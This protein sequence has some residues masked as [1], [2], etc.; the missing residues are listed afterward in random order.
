MPWAKENSQAKE[1]SPADTP[2]VMPLDTL[3][4]GKRFHRQR[5][6][7][8]LPG[9]ASALRFQ[10]HRFAERSPDFLR[11]PV[12]PSEVVQKVFPERVLAVLRQR[13]ALGVELP[14]DVGQLDAPVRLGVADEALRILARGNGGQIPEELPADERD[15]S[16]ARAEVLLGA[17]GD[18]PLADPG[19]DVLVDHVARDPAP[20][21]RVPDR[22]APRGNAF[23][24]VGLGFLRHA[25]KGP[26]DREHVLVVHRYAP[27]E[28]LA[29]KKTVRPQT[30]AACRPQRIAFV[31]AFAHAFV[32]VAGLELFEADLQLRG[33]VGTGA[34]LPAQAPVPV[35]P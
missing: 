4:G 12:V 5:D 24:L 2:S 7:R 17:V 18:A 30:H 27:L 31:G 23:L 33:R 19:D 8:S 25:D 34:A 20:G 6:L 3:A 9:L 29:E 26:G 10:T 35:L 22:R 13:H 32:A 11:L 1:N 28:V 21:L 15:P 16:V 14:A